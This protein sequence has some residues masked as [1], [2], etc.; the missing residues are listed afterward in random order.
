M[1]MKPLWN[2][3]ISVMIGFSYRPLLRQL[4]RQRDGLAFAACLDLELLDLAFDLK[5]LRM[6]FAFDLDHGVLRQRP[7]FDLA[8]I[9]ATTSWHPCPSCADLHSR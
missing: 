3:D 4:V 2:W 1:A 8:D 7:V 5:G 9:P 6:R